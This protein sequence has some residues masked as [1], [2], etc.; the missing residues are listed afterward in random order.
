MENS[1][2]LQRTVRK[3][4]AALAIAAILGLTVPGPAPAAGEPPA[5]EESAAAGEPAAAGAWGWL[6]EAWVDA[7]A[8]AAAAV[9]LFL[10]QG[11]GLDPNG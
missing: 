6:S 2:D 4:A 3:T 10:D 5:A 8:L 7:A 1:K 9:D 11:A